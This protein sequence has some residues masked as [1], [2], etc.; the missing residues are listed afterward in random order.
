MRENQTA[1]A[2]FD[3]SKGEVDVDEERG[4]GRIGGDEFPRGG[5]DDCC[6]G[7]IGEIEH[8]GRIACRGEELVAFGGSV[9]GLERC[10]KVAAAFDML[11]AE[12]SRECGGRSDESEG[13]FHQHCS[14]WDVVVERVF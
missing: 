4:R 6:G 5:G 13:E 7:G 1:G 3:D 10:G 8:E 9:G 2:D 11:V 12:G 14:M